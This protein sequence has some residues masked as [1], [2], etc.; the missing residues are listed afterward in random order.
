MFTIKLF[1]NIKLELVFHFFPIDDT[2]E[3]IYSYFD[4]KFRDGLEGF[5]FVINILLFGF[6]LN[7]YNDNWNF[8]PTPDNFEYYKAY[9]N[10]N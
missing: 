8:S 6:E 2:I 9:S 5:F 1:R 3:L 7:I 4:I 10:L